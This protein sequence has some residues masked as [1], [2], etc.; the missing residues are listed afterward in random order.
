MKKG[1]QV[2]EIFHDELLRDCG[3]YREICES[4]LTEEEVSR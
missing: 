2:C 1:I 4:Q 3:V